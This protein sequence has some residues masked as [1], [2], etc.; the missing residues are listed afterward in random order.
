MTPPHWL[1]AA[2]L[3]AC[4]TPAAAARQ[5][6]GV[7]ERDHADATAIL[8]AFDAAWSAGDLDGLVGP[9]APEFGCEI[10]DGVD[11]RHLR[12]TL[13]NLRELLPGTTCRTEVLQLKGDGRVLQAF[14]CRKFTGA[15][16]VI[17]EL[18][19]VLY[20]RRTQNKLRLIGLEEFDHAGFERLTAGR[21]ANETCALSFEL[22]P[23]MFVVP[24]PP[25][26]FY[27]E[28]LLLRGDDLQ[29]VIELVLLHTSRPYVL[30]DA[31]EH[32]LDRWLRDNMPAKVETR[33]RTTLAGFPAFRAVA[34]YSGPECSLT[35]GDD[36]KV[37]PR[38]L[39]RV[40]VQLGDRFLLAV[41]LKT[42][43]ELHG[44][45]TDRLDALLDSLVVDVPAA[46]SYADVVGRRLGWGC[47]PEGRF[48]S[49]EAGF[50]VQAPPGFQLELFRTDSLFTVQ[51]RRP[52]GS[53]I[54][55]IDGVEKLDPEVTLEEHIAVDETQ[56]GEALARK[57]LMVSGRS[58]VQ[59]DRQ[60][61][62]A[63]IDYESVIYIGG[64]RYLFTV[65]VTGT[66]DEVRRATD[67]LNAIL[68]GISIDT[69]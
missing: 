13:E 3:L 30:E 6:D 15:A 18:C 39:T 17:E 22:P 65:R 44:A 63:G 38:R 53:A 24:R 2:L 25:P 1:Q 33:T 60:L 35:R 69:P 10:Y 37:T 47:L 50:V 52:P 34:R 21:Y 48:E 27:L 45:A 5:R 32:D 16:G 26:G 43:R 20:L 41:D 59:V 51:A 68:R 14:L 42:P 31:I 19:H 8:T 67:D 56:R 49:R 57:S 66:E 46:A 40:Y 36:R 11:A 9:V 28:R 62:R 54:I 55:R 12:A 7:T 29:S 64:G 58:A 23:G 61:K 4:L